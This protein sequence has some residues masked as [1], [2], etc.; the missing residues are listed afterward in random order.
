MDQFEIDG[1]VHN[2]EYFYIHGKT[3]ILRKAFWPALA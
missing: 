1:D 3:C 2:E